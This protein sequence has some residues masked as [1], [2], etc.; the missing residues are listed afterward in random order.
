MSKK[1]S[2]KYVPNSLSNA[3]KKK[4][5]KSIKERTIRPKLSSFKSKKSSWIKKFEKKYGTKITDSNF[6]HKNIITK[7]G[8]KLIINK[9]MGAYYTSGSRPNQT[10]QSWGL[11]RLASVLLKGPAYKIDRGIYDKYKIRK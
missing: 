6:I 9:G 5:I 7:K 10:P 3:D 8:Q 2:K 11:A 4:Q 1:F